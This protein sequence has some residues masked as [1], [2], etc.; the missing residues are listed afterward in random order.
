VLVKRCSETEAMALDSATSAVFQFLK[1]D[2]R[3]VIAIA[4]AGDE[5]I[6]ESE[7]LRQL[8][9]DTPKLTRQAVKGVLASLA[10]GCLI[11]GF[12]LPAR[13]SGGGKF[14]PSMQPSLVLGAVTLG[15]GMVLSPESALAASC[16]VPTCTSRGWT[17]GTSPG[18]NYCWTPGTSFTCDANCS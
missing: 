12:E 1:L 3:I 2:A 6:G 9:K 13:R 14:L 10:A 18:R 4:D 17:C 8:S 11:D 7:L 16:T 5:G 15:A